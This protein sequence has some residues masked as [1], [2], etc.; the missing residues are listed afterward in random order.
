MLLRDKGGWEMEAT[1]YRAP[2]TT[3][4]CVP[5]FIFSYTGNKILSKVLSRDCVCFE[6]IITDKIENR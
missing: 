5:K 6:N 4:S 1:F 3:L 2:Y